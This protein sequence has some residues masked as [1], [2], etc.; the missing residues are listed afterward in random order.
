MWRKRRQTV[1]NSIVLGD[2]NQFMKDGPADADPDREADRLREHVLFRARREVAR[3]GLQQPTMIPVSWRGSDRWVQPSRAVLGTDPGRLSGTVHRIPDVCRDL[4]RHQVVVLGEPGTG[5]S[6][7]ALSLVHDMADAPQPGDP[8]P[9]LMSLSSWRPA[10]PMRTWIIRQIRQNGSGPAARRKVGAQAAAAL[11]DACRVMPVL[12]GLDELPQPL[13]ARAVEAID[14]AIPKGCWLLLTCRAE[15]YEATCR[16]GSRLT[17]AAVVELRAVET[18]MAIDY[19]RQSKVAGDRR[20]DA[21]FE[22]IRGRPEST[23]ART[24]ASPLMLYLTQ[25]AYQASA[26]EPAE[27]LSGKEYASRENIEDRLLDRYLPAAYAESAP[28]PYTQTRARRYLSLIAR[29]MGRDGTVDF[30]WWQIRSLLTGPAVGL[31][32]GCTWGWF[33]YAL[34]GSGW[35]LATGL[36]TG[37]VSL[38]AHAVVRY[39][40]KQVYVPEGALRGPRALVRHYALI[41][42][43]SALAVAAVT[44]VCVS[45]WLTRDLNAQAPLARHYGALVGA[46]SGAAA[47]LGSAWGSYQASRLWF[48]LTGRLPRRLAHFLEDAHRR[49]VLRQPGAVYQFRHERLLR[50]LGARAV[51]EPYRSV[52]GEWSASWR[53]WGPLLPVFATT[54]QVGS[55]LVVLGTVSLLYATTSGVG[56]DYRSGDK[57]GYGART[58]ACAPSSSDGSCTTVDV[59]SWKVPAGSSRHTVW[60]PATVR[61]RSIQ[62]WSGRIG[63]RG[64]AHASVEV[65]LALTGQAPAAFTVRDSSD[66]PAADLPHPVRPERR[67]V[68]V[69]LRRLDHRPCTLLVEWTGPG[70]VDDALE[71]V[72]KRL[73]IEAAGF[74]VRV[75]TENSRITVLRN[76]AL[77]PIVNSA[78]RVSSR[79]GNAWLVC[80]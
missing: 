49:G 19:L 22:A 17:R 1:R 51:K 12:D 24:M 64:C 52:Q 70:L 31:A 7:L 27:L 66:A 8:V 20:W 61:D 4:P 9:V 75:H 46:A 50:L 55:A 47:L 13:R 80:T 32:F 40:L 68:S 73:G 54:A 59:W 48:W 53:R 79:Y 65:T 16:A 3:L 60:L 28:G 39:E 15:Q 42:V 26:T 58:V 44:G 78:S 77:P 33:L 67:P 30:A 62:R 38:T 43:G 11:F 18:R 23:L 74:P 36:L 57:P 14:A 76:T 29:Q 56:L 69:T 35:G 34:L 5:K 37:L 21:V 6:V 72:R 45:W 63:A 10:V 2:V 71:P 25:T 41:G